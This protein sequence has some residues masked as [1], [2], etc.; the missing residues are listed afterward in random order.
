M[1]K[2]SIVVLA[3]VLPSLLG[4]ALA[5]P[6]IVMSPVAFVAD[7]VD[8]FE[9][10]GGPKGITTVTIG[11]STYALA[12]ASNDDGVQIVDITDPF[13]PSP[14]AAVTDGVDGFEELR[15]ARDITTV[16][17]GSSTYALVTAT[18]DDGVQI[19]D[20]TDPSSPAP[21]AHISAASDVALHGA[22][23]IATFTV[24]SSTYAIVTS[25]SGG[26]QIVD[27]TDPS[28]PAPVASIFGGSEIGELTGARGI[29]TTTIGSSTYALVA[30]FLEDAVQIINITDPF[31][32]SPIAVVRNSQ[33][34]RL[35]G[36]TGITTA[37]I[38]SSTYALV[39]VQ[40]DNAVQIINITDPSSPD[41]VA[42]AQD[43][44]GGFDK[45]EYPEGIVAFT[46]GSSTYAIVAAFQDG[47]QMI[48][49]TD[50]SS[51]S[52][53]ASVG[54]FDARFGSFSFPEDIAVVT[55]DSKTYALA[56]SFFGNGIPI[57]DVALTSDPELASAALDEGTG[58]LEI[59]FSNAI[60]VTPASMVD[61]SGLT[62]R[63]SGQSVPLTGATLKTESDSAVI[64]I[65][66]TGDQRSSVAAMASPQLDISGSAV[67]D[68]SGNPIGPSSG[69]TITINEI[70]AVTSIE[71]SSGNTTT[72][73]EIPTVTSIERSSPATAIT[74]ERSLV[75]EVT[76][77]ENVTGVGLA[78]FVLSSNGTGTGSVTNLTG[79]GSVYYVTVSATQDGTY[80]LDIAQNSGIEDAAGNPLADTAPSPD[81]SFTVVPANTAPVLNAIPN[82]TVDELSTLTFTAD[83]IDVDI[84]ANTLTYGLDGEPAGAS[85]NP[86][87]G[88]F[89]W[90]PTEAQGPGTYTFNVT[91]SDGNGGSDSQAVTVNV[92][93]SI[94]P[95]VTT[96]QT[97]RANE[98]ITIPVAGAAGV[99]T[100]DWGDGHVSTDVT[101]DQRHRYSDAGTHTVSITGDFTR[102]YLN[103]QQPNA[104]KLQ[105]IEQWGDI[106]WSSM[107]GAFR[108]A[109][110]MEYRATDTP[111]LSGVTNMNRMFNHADLFDGD[112]SGWDVSAVTDMSFMFNTAA[113][114]NQP[115]DSWDVSGVTDMSSMFRDADA[116]N[117]P[118]SDWNV[119]AVTDM[120]TMFQNTATFNQ[121]L[122]DWDV[123]AVTDMS[124]MF[125]G[126][127]AFNGDISDWDVSAVTDTSFMFWMASV[128][129]QPLSDW[130]VS[131]VTDMP[132]MFRHA[133]AFNQ[134]LNDWDVSSATDM[135]YMLSDAISFNQPLN[136]WD[137][138]SATDMH[139][140]FDSATSFNQPISDWNV[141]AVTD[142][143]SMFTGADA[144][145]QPLSD[146]N[147]S[148]V[149]DM[150][151][152]FT[153]A[154]AFN[155]DISGWDVSSVTDMYY[156]FGS[157]T[158]FNRSLNDWDVSSV[159]DMR[160]MFSGATAF[161]Q[162][163]GNWYIV[164]DDTAVDY[165]DAPGIVGR[166]SPQNS[167]LD[168]QNPAY[169]I[170][171]G[172]DSDS[173][174]LNGDNLT[175]KV[176]PVK[177]SYA[178][179]VA[180]TGNFGTNNS[181]VIGITVTN[182]TGNPPAVF[183]GSDQTVREGDTVTLNGTA[184]Y[185]DGDTLTYQWTHDSSLAIPLSD[186]AALTATFTAP[187][188]NA[189]TDVT[190][191]FTV[192]DGTNTAI[193][194]VT[195]T[196]TPTSDPP[197]VDAGSDQ[198]VREGDTVTLSG[199]V[200][201]I[202]S[203]LPAYS[204][205]HDSALDI[206]FNATSHTITFAAPQVGA[207][208]AIT[209]TLTA[210]YDGS[211]YSDSIILSVMDAPGTTASATAFVTTWQ[212]TQANERITIPVG[213]ATG[214]YTIDW[215]DGHTSAN[216][217]G[218]QRHTYDDAGTYTVSITGDFTR[219]LLAG[220][221]ANAQK[222]QSIEQWGDMR[223]E[224]MERAFKDASN[225]VYHATDVPN[226]S[227]VTSM[228]KM[229]L[230][231][232]SFDGDLSGWDVSTVTDMS[233]A[234]RDASSFDGD[235]SG[236][237]VSSVTDMSSMFELATSF[238][239]DL[240]TWD[241]SSVTDMAH[242]FYGANTFDGNISTWD[243]S[244]VTDMGNM[245]RNAASF[246]GDLGN[247]N[248]SAVADMSR[249]FRGT[250]S[251]GVDLS[252]WDVSRVTTMYGMFQG[253]SSF[254]GDI[255]TWDVSSV[256]NMDLMFN[257]ARSFEQNLG[258]WYVTLGDAEIEYDDATR[259]IT[260]IL[261]QNAW[262]EDNHSIAYSVDGDA[263]DGAL[264]EIDGAVL[265]LKS[266]PSN[267]QSS[268]EL[269]I[270][271]TGDFGTSNSKDVV[272]TVTW[273]PP[274]TPLGVDA[275][276]DQ[277]VQEGITATLTGTATNNN[278]GTLTYQW[279]HNSTLGIALA[280][281]TSLSTT[282]TAPAV[283]ADIP[284]A[285]TLTVDDG[286]VTAADSLVVTV[287]DV[288][289]ANSQPVVD[290]GTD[291]TVQEGQT[292]TLNGT[293]TDG[294]DLTYAWSHDSTME[295]SFNASSPAATFP[296]P[297]VSSDTT[298]TFTLT[299]SDGSANSTDTV[300]V[301]VSDVPNDT[302][303]VTTWETATPG[304]S[305][306]IPARGT[307]TVDWGDGTV[308]ADVR[309]SQTHAYATAGN[310]TV[311]ISDSVTGFHLDGH[312]DASK[313]RSVDQWG[314]ARWK[315]MYSS[316]KGA[317]NMILHATDVPD[318]SR[319]KD[320]RYMFMD[321]RS[322]DGD[323]SGWDVSRV[324]D[325]RYMFMN[326]RSFDGDLSGW[327]VSRVTDMEG[328]F[329]EARSFDGDLS[330]WDVSSVTDMYRM[331][332]KARSFDGDVSAWSVSSVANMNGMFS[333][334]SSFNG[335]LSGWDVSSVTN[336][337]AMFAGASS[338]NGDLSAWDVSSVTDMADMLRAA[339]SFNGDLSGWDI[340]SVTRMDAMFYEADAFDQNLGPWYIVLD[341]AVIDSSSVP[342]EV[343]RIA[344]QNSF[345]DD[346]NPAYGIGT[347]GDSEHFEIDGSIL[348]M[349]SV[350]DGHAGPYSVTIT[351]TGTYGSE[352]SR[353]FDISVTE[354]TGN[355]PSAAP[356]DPR[357]VG[358]I[359][360]TSTQPGTIE[361]TWDAPGEVPRDYRV[362]WAK[363]GE[364]FL[365][366]SDLAGNAFPTSPGHTVTSLEE[367]EEYKVKVRA[368]YNGGGSGDWSGVITITVAGT[369]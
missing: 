215:G 36:A 39:T 89:S 113:S 268:Y 69:N 11:S 40:H 285:F 22:F 302:D 357:D 352:N 241:V 125:Y 23:G 326:A 260:T 105:S 186:A 348:K 281:S 70:P 292:V 369:G 145:N 303:F 118:L 213:D 136:D 313:L 269:T 77:S 214:I 304:D 95:F 154:D 63:D 182:Y 211:T 9:E 192:N 288:P 35:D 250:S 262:L 44:S 177:S 172:G 271:S 240:S 264:F 114:F 325:A 280:N 311:R 26:I 193:D 222:L 141:S 149:T 337:Y 17:V 362:A 333:S 351:S 3:L 307:Y 300:L 51:P 239:G 346:Q 132:S 168:G 235:I 238:N 294:D 209:F 174:E 139:G 31:N 201:N 350:P 162:N 6:S 327:D 80:N 98:R 71:P 34:N 178:V 246:D 263:D 287:T 126:T 28:S 359:T 15:G 12:A 358:E 106:R 43:G 274:N 295:I 60:D 289:A 104:N 129:N 324:N 116:F 62:I 128:F 272:V 21:T 84:P 190:F 356:S 79:S 345:L 276:I 187:A 90:S 316:F 42:F 152:M 27:I 320:A 341:D 312:S 198:T 96:W 41:S 232:S 205:S 231:A 253:A 82:Q 219:F 167:V 296:A 121:T 314:D 8:G 58:V 299:V 322:F 2:A 181:R 93:D 249:M 144:F 283:D 338:F 298:V 257:G 284:V 110:S 83:A 360:L 197:S 138:S 195:V 19:I 143:S 318:L 267:T 340:T 189:D 221:L 233:R 184:T 310:H 171:S 74:S 86:A 135:S 217:S 120:S 293:A 180:S 335:D 245:F 111:D 202:D 166:I 94:S 344:A 4:Y 244:S 25:S 353:T 334:A 164:L 81:Q 216:V 336:M 65:E 306:T 156:M 278:G 367:G 73:N 1:V 66:L 123:S 13:N 355:A 102:I 78:D 243:V 225:M 92:N 124:Y 199:T 258:N 179:T 309:N 297:L 107:K 308:D 191:T 256:T 317:S 61:L 347:G 148:A 50:P 155:G 161:G 127:G 109:F 229:F 277:T 265:K 100:V 108:G 151:F 146:W 30:V 48:N 14:V 24:G 5:A 133:F 130:N 290:A 153:S 364:N 159:T 237:N 247:W 342:G 147:V 270:L 16:T 220:G 91:V 170:R 236:W 203:S 204:W 134:P 75:F 248:V 54:S 224:S 72:I 160:S 291:Q 97:T 361:I 183:A 206:P 363:V 185:G 115:L 223:W 33:D 56:A 286:T 122:S 150:T 20:I 230:R 242:M 101:G 321:A 305:I 194:H 210:D 234:F 301:T 254:N 252:G 282:F 117:Q 88:A 142:M 349:K 343:G 228:H 46:I 59:E 251:F 328:M 207:N 208:T 32:P 103:G 55:I 45:L 259:R 319:V 227:G 165:N 329:W 368:R 163:L 67:T 49:I 188:V 112:I 137:V 140:M 157:A 64:S 119:S 196:I 57:I 339:S 332:N 85:I 315:S 226:L 365:A 173:F 76:F 275:G 47:I 354:G 323:L 218:D 273:I 331:F 266:I 18:A 99:Y 7:G 10:L 279:N 52:P 212:T 29:T 255:S 68:I 176:A 330:G 37:T 131:A 366:R 87:T 53:A 38:G 200:A 158:S 169:R 261:P 175:L